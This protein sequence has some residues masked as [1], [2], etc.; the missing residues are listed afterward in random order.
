MTATTQ[1]P[2]AGTLAAT[3]GKAPGAG[4]SPC[5]PLTV[6]GAD[7]LSPKLAAAPRRRARPWH[8]SLAEGAADVSRPPSFGFKAK[9][10][11]VNGSG[12]LS[13]S[14][15]SPKNATSSSIL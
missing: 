9:L 14:I 15:T 1:Q 6:W 4:A 11:S 12:P 10:R 7:S 8:A 5:R 13:R 3:P 2:C